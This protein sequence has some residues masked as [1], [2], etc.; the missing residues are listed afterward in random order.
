M[1]NT[2]K[3]YN[4]YLMNGTIEHHNQHQCSVHLIDV[5]ME[6]LFRVHKIQKENI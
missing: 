5:A 2:Q 1:Q 4:Y 3:A 6:P